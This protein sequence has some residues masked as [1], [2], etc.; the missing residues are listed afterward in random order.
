MKKVGL[1]S[2]SIIWERLTGR[3]SISTKISLA[4]L[5]SMIIILPV[6]SLSTHYYNQLGKSLE[7]LSKKDAAIINYSQKIRREV[8]SLNRIEDIN[9]LTENEN[10]FKENNLHLDMIKSYIDSCRSLNE[11]NY[12]SDLDSISAAYT[13]F[14]IGFKALEKEVQASKLRIENMKTNWEKKLKLSKYR[15]VSEI[16]SLK[17]VMEK[18]DSE[19]DEKR[20]EN[21]KQEI[22]KILGRISA[23]S[24]NIEY[25]QYSDPALKFYIREFKKYSLNV[26]T[27]TEK[28][29][30][31]AWH[32]FNSLSA[33]SSRLSKKA[34]KNI[35]TV[36]IIS[37]LLSLAQ[38]IIIP[39]W[40][41]RPIT[42][43]NNMLQR[44][45]RGDDPMQIEITSKDEITKFAKSLQSLVHKMKSID[46]LKQEFIINQ[47]IIIKRISNMYTAGILVLNK[48]FEITM[49]N[50][51]VKKNLDLDD[52][53]LDYN[54][55]E[56]DDNR[57]LMGALRT[58][59][60]KMDVL[61]IPK[62]A[63]V[64]RKREFNC[65]LEIIPIRDKNGDLFRFI[66]V[67]VPL[68]KESE[69]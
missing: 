50:E 5:L 3:F 49:M 56:I 58:T 51:I 52:D 53:M 54:I 9:Y 40:I 2:G 32:H 37:L 63:F 30:N 64:S 31:L 47:Q 7:S 65:D 16:E 61:K 22:T 66:I 25:Q 44:I 67:M 27:K 34:R 11:K 24:L 59:K 10:A 19:R 43:L 4:Q 8:L 13:N 62:F 69:S 46:L 15:L 21:Y 23:D 28:M 14:Q 55:S 36:L 57:A 29:Q 17:E 48:H 35:I 45:D 33:E 6:V 20:R 1:S 39:S 26:D 41:T 42:F 60:S 38:I 18:I 12:K 68:K